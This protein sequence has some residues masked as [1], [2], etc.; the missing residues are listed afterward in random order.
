LNIINEIM[1]ECAYG[2]IGEGSSDAKKKQRE[3]ERVQII[4]RDH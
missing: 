1:E 4:A 3:R 2:A